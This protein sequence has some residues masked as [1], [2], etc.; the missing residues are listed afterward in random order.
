MMTSG[1]SGMPAVA[2]VLPLVWAT[3][4][5]ANAVGFIMGG[6]PSAVGMIATL[7]AACA[8]PA[9][10]W[11]AASQSRTGFIRLATV[12]WITVVAGA[13]LALWALTSAE[14][15][16]VSQGEI[17][18]PAI[19]FALAAPLYGLAGA[20]PSWEPAV[21]T[22]LVG[23][24]VFALTVLAYVARQRIGRRSARTSPV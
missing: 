16:T 2:V 17:V 3:A 8:W 6:P 19:L 9:A 20:L 12:F 18:L 11:Y 22:M 10:G 7:V 24:V 5:A 15:M 14:G 1:K 13:P 21:Q 23:L 4:G